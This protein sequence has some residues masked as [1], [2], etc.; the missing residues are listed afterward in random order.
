MRKPIIA[1]ILAVVSS[2]ANA[3]WVK[4]YS[5]DNGT[6]NA[7]VDSATIRKTGNTVRMWH[8]VDIKTV[9]A[10]GAD[11]PF[12]SQKSEGEYDCKKNQSRT[13]FVSQHSENMGRGDV[14]NKA[15]DYSAWH[16]K[17]SGAQVKTLWEF[18]CGSQ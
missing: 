5:N 15:G 13:L 14:V 11:R 16:P 7:Y 18:A 8:L 1:L 4:I 17:P 6:I 10:P 2:G 3:E 9:M 12:R